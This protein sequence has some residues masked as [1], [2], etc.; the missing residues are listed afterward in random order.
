MKVR[1]EKN[2]WM[3]QKL[4]EI[5]RLVADYLNSKVNRL[6]QSA[7]KLAF[8]S[9]GIMIALLC[10]QLIFQSVNGKKAN[11]HNT[12]DKITLPYD[13]QPRSQSSDSIS[14]TKN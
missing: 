14:A 11:D 5:Q 2:N 4:K 13:I 3:S 7:K 8:L 10:L 12:V 1:N 6:S 9:L